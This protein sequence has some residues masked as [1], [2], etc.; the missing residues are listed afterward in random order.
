MYFL[1]QRQILCTIST[2]TF[3][4]VSQS[5]IISL[6]V[7]LVHCLKSF[8][9][10]D[11]FTILFMNIPFTTMTKLSKFNA[12]PCHSFKCSSN[13]SKRVHL[14]SKCLRVS[15]KGKNVT[16]NKTTKRKLKQKDKNILMKLQIPEEGVPMKLDYEVWKF[17]FSGLDDRQNMP[18][19]LPQDSTCFHVKTTL[20]IV[21]TTEGAKLDSVFTL[22]P[23][24]DI[25]YTLGGSKSFA[26]LEQV[27]QR[28]RQL[29]STNNRGVRK[30]PV[31]TE[32]KTVY[33]TLGPCPNRYGKG[34][35]TAYK[36]L[37]DNVRHGIY[38]II[39]QIERVTNRYLPSYQMEGIKLAKQHI[40]WPTFEYS[41][42]TKSE[43]FSNI[44]IG[45]NVYL[46]VHTDEDAFYSVAFVLADMK[47]EQN[48]EIL[49][50]FCF[51]Q[52]GLAVAMRQGDIL[53]FN[54][55]EPHCISSKRVSQDIMCCSIYLKSKLVGGN[56]NSK[57]FTKE[58]RQCQKRI[59]FM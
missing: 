35:I 2:V 47:V 52:K 45:K 6:C 26:I 50:Y 59:K 46:P 19:G 38:N 22:V 1:L 29:K 12:A 11:S 31:S 10:V 40:K 53:I 55:L 44:A 23:R 18:K 58:E 51:P 25:L 24:N 5:Y 7:P 3:G 41:E 21:D 9:R 36:S 42:N 34:C 15:N 30:N 28:T 54:P 49:A 33:T 14:L 13:S 20:K 27:D 8:Y 17:F 37:T 32:T 56:D 4:Y 43:Y 48:S 57:E 39:H 16:G